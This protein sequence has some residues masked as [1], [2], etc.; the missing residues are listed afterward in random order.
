MQGTKMKV[1]D[2]A[3]SKNASNEQCKEL[4]RKVIDN[5]SNDNTSNGNCM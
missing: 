1:I 3:S 2:N 5:A 4:K